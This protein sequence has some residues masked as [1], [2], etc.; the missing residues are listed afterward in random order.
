MDLLSIAG[1]IL[2][3][4]VVFVV[5]RFVLHLAG[6]VIGCILTALIALGILWLLFRF[7]F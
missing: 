4:I 1:F 7:V 3:V 2:L 6:K 5:A